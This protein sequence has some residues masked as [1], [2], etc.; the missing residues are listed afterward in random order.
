MDLAGS[1]ALSKPKP[2]VLN[3]DVS[4]IERPR[5]FIVACDTKNKFFPE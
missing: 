3:V 5:R 1:L 4:R 2:R